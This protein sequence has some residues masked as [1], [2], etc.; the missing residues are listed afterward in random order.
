MLDALAGVRQTQERLE[1]T[2]SRHE[3]MLAMTFRRIADVQAQVDVLAMR[4]VRRPRLGK[5]R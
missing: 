3:E 5:K 4:G 1:A 2:V